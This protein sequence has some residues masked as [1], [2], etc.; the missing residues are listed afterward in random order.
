MVVSVDIINLTGPAWP[1]DKPFNWSELAVNLLF[2]ESINCGTDILI[3]TPALVPTH[4]VS[5]QTWR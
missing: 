2:P 3:N 1:N 5:L 4:N